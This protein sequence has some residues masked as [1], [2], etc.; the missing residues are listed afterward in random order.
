MVRICLLF[1]SNG[2]WHLF[3]WDAHFPTGIEATLWGLAS[4]IMCCSALIHNGLAMLKGVQRLFLSALWEGRFI[5]DNYVTGHIQVSKALMLDF[6]L[7]KE[8]LM[9]IMYMLALSYIS[10]VFFILVESLISTRKLARGS[11]N[12]AALF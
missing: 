3:S 6:P 10:T 5:S 7:W 1:T 12:T 4:L 11:F 9:L 2:L 8:I